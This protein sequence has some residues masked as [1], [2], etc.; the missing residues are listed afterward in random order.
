MEVES[1]PER[2]SHELLLR[3]AG[4]VP[5]RYLW[6]YRDWLAEGA[7]APLAQ[8]LPLTL[9]RER[10]SVTPGEFGLLVDA[11]APSGA[12]SARITAIHETD[13]PQVET[14]LFSSQPPEQA[15]LGDQATV[16]LTA[17]LKDREDVG[18]V[19]MS[20]RRKHH[21]D[22]VAKRVLLVASS[23][24][25]AKL[26]GE[27][28]RVLRAVG[29]EEPAVEVIPP[30]VELPAYHRAALANAVVLRS[31]LDHTPSPITGAPA[32]ARA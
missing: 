7:T 9:L 32:L 19:R 1:I 22:A 12:D 5:D 27:L 11:L 8:A 18:E 30:N 15:Q 10:I 29:D 24:R 13:D 31:G 25:P 20:W 17:L 4:R 21:D 2:A 3:L 26:T 28:Q 23:G 16:V 14:F 6:R